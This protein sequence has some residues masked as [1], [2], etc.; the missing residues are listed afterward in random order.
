MSKPRLGV[1]RDHPLDLVISVFGVLAK[2]VT[3]EP[4]PLN[5]AQ[6]TSRIVRDRLVVSVC[7]RLEIRLQE[8]ALALE[9]LELGGLHRGTGGLGIF[10]ELLGGSSE[11]NL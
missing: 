5:V 9:L 8:Q 4:C 10:V 1:V 7:S 2:F 6:E 3:I 11:Q